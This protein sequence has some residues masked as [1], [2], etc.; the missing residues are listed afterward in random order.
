MEMKYLPPPPPFFFPI[1]LDLRVH[2]F[3]SLLGTSRRE[4]R[5]EPRKNLHK[6]HEQTYFFAPVKTKVKPNQNH[7]DFSIPLLLYIL[8]HRQMKEELDSNCI[9]YYLT[10]PR[11]QVPGFTF[12]RKV[13]LTSVGMEAQE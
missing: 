5:R 3:Q 13:G 9:P 7:P 6:L 2:P 4:W 10:I 8:K 1:D 12:S 11:A